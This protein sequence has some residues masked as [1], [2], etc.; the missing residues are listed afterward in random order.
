MVAPPHGPGE[1][2]QT[3][4]E[5]PFPAQGVLPG[6]GEAEIEEPALEGGQLSGQRVELFLQ[7]GVLRMV[8]VTLQELRDLPTGPL[9]LVDPRGRLVDHLPDGLQHPHLRSD[10]VE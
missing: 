6:F 9:R 3:R 8:F 10:V 1:I 5:Q 2:P 4:V 7:L